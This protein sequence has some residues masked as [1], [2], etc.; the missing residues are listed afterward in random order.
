M[1]EAMAC[2][3]PVIAWRCGAVPEIVDHN[4]TGFIVASE[5][6]AVDAVG[7]VEVSIGVGSAPSSSDVSR[8][9]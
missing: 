9:P 2:G 7:R 4:V 5:D 6:E 3:T 1:I 8:R